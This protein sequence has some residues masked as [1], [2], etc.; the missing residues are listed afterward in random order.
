MSKTISS[1]L[2]VSLLIGISL[3]DPTPF[4]T[5]IEYPL[6][7]EIKKPPSWA[8]DNDSQKYFSL[9]MKFTTEDSAYKF[10][11]HLGQ[12]QIIHGNQAYTNPDQPD[13]KV[14]WGVKCIQQN[15]CSY[16][17]KSSD[18]Y[19]Y[20][21]NTWNVTN[22]LTQFSLTTDKA[23]LSKAPMPA[24]LV[25]NPMK[26]ADWLFDNTGILGLSPTSPFWTYLFSQYKMNNDEIGLNFWLSANKQEKLSDLFEESRQGLYEGSKFKLSDSPEKFLEVQDDTLNFV[27]S[28][29]GKRSKD[30]WGISKV[31]VHLKDD[32]D[33]PVHTDV[34]ACISSMAVE[35]VISANFGLM[36]ERV[37]KLICG[38]P[39]GCSSSKNLSYA[40]E[41]YITFLDNSQKLVNITLSAEDYM[42]YDSNGGISASF[43]DASAYEAVDCP[44]GLQLGF[45]RMFLFKKLVTM[46]IKK[47]KDGNLIPQIAIN[48]YKTRPVLANKNVNSIVIFGGAFLVFIVLLVVFMRSKGNSADKT[49]VSGS[50]KLTR[51]E[52]QFFKD[53]EYESVGNGT[54]RESVPD[55][56]GFEEEY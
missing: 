21:G 8:T 55:K 4:S 25:F 19:Y 38:N 23:D 44:P 40:P 13:I 7:F 24:L 51:N 45:G 2:I 30:Y 47:N 29:T 10:R 36:T 12:S 41:M 27:D 6:T 52:T 32:M 28:M 15:S 1:F 39:K 35:T 31:S 54:D 16:D 46:K 9:Q 56:D 50:S 26:S 34:E 18:N 22:T 49:I 5:Y 14:E 33:K 20:D 11:P 42:Y 53:G 3:Q 17:L 43:G 37:M 48:N